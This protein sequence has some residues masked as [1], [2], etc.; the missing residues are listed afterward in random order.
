MDLTSFESDAEHRADDDE[1]GTATPRSD[2]SRSQ[3]SPKPDI[4]ALRS[5]RRARTSEGTER[6]TTDDSEEDVAG[7][8]PLRLSKT[9]TR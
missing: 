2:G 6:D 5:R 3:R 7:L 9:T 1:I 8:S 4:P